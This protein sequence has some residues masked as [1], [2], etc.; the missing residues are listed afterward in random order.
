MSFN[1]IELIE[2]G[3]E[4]LFKLVEGRRSN[5]KLR[6]SFG[7]SKK[8]LR[9]KFKGF[10]L[11]GRKNI[12]AEASYRGA[13]IIG[14]SGSGKSRTCI[15][16][17]IKSM[18]GSL[19]IHDPSGEL[20]D[21]AR[22]SLLAKGYDIKVFNA[23]DVFSSESFN[24]LKGVTTNGEASRKARSIVEASYGERLSFWEA[25]AIELLSLCIAYLAR[26]P[27]S[28]CNLPK[29]WTM[30][31]HFSSDIHMVVKAFKKLDDHELLDRCLAFAHQE[32]KMRSGVLATALSCLSFLSD[33]KVVQVT[34]SDSIDLEHIRER[35]TALFIQ[36]KTTDA[37]YHSV[38]NSLLFEKLFETVLDHLPLSHEED[39]FFLI[40]E[41]GGLLI[42]SLP[43]I[44]SPNVRKYRSGI[45]LSVQDYQMLISQYGKEQAQTIRSNCYSTLVFAG[46]GLEEC[47]YLERLCGSYEYVND[48]G[49]TR[50]RPL[51]AA[52]EVRTMNADTA[53]LLYGN[54]APMK[55]RLYQPLTPF[56]K[57]LRAKHG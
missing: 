12:S 26:N 16:P 13:L 21:A 25:S 20:L 19:V 37:N 38:L 49:Q 23:S 30:V 56:I 33:E 28:S 31:R 50:V 42:P 1:P 6:A 9:R 39:V 5:D 57:R 35:K 41:A 4:N 44:A 47:Q 52:S 29:L 51:I 46:A 10:S 53:L 2:I 43:K 14:G 48:L 24:F 55:I 18:D 17:S 22:E 8:I 11:G 54:E 15:T 32:E 3:L 36:S 45:L 34:N 27:K 40:D 7:S